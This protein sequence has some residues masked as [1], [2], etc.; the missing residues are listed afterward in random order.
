[1]K[2]PV[3]QILWDLAP[4]LRT[5]VREVSE[6]RAPDSDGGPAITPEEWEEIG[7]QIGLRLGAVVLRHLRRANA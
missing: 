4:T 6:A 7:A 2:V 5:A 3:I 1:M